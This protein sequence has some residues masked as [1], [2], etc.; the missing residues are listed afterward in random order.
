MFS[1]HT[2]SID[3]QSPRIFIND[4]LFSHGSQRGIARYVHHVTN[5]IISRF[6]SSTIICSSQERDYAPAKHIRQLVFRGSRRLGVNTAWASLAALRERATVL[7]NPYYGNTWTNATR[8]YTVYDMIHELYP[9][10]FPSADHRVRAFI[11]EKKRC[12]TEADVLIAISDHTAQDI[13]TCYPA[14]KAKILVTHLGVEQ[15]FFDSQQLT[16]YSNQKPYFLFVGHRTFHK[17][18][19]RLLV[20]FSESRL[21]RDFDLLIIS[22]D[23]GGFTE[24][25]KAQI[26]RY[27]LQQHVRLLTNVDE[28]TLR[29]SYA[30]AAAFVYPS[31]YEGF[32]LPILEA[33]ASGTIVATSNTSSMPEVGGEVALYFDPRSIESI[34][35]CLQQVAAMAQQERYERVA[36]GIARAQTFTWQRC[37]QQTVELFEELG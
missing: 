20:A 23:T 21:A 33:M 29:I 7:F 27:Q 10:W 31:E 5:G 34:S 2:R 9:N 18:F 1:L 11:A 3:R 32:G 12:I 19:G 28:Q 25:E 17:N 35:A 22:P 6:G 30:G 8:V 14:T 15:F 37:Q 36:A 13:M 24:Q 4:N 26:A 16:S